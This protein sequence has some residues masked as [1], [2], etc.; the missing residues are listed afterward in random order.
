MTDSLLL[1]A[2]FA[3]GFVAL[4]FVVGEVAGFLLAR[5]LV[6]RDERDQHEG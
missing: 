3:L 5:V 6:R 2:L 4:T 1:T